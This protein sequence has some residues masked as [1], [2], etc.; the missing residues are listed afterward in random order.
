MGRKSLCAVME[1]VDGAIRAAGPAPGVGRVEDTIRDDTSADT[2][3]TG[4]AALLSCCLPTESS[5]GVKASLGGGGAE[6]APVTAVVILAED[7]AAAATDVDAGGV[8]GKETAGGFLA[9]LGFHFF[10]FHV[11]LG[12]LPAADEADD[13]L[14]VVAEEDAKK[15]DVGLRL[16]EDA[17]R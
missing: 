4:P 17:S 14:S 2:P 3:G 12:F 6:D 1:A 7:A 9:P 10:L 11:P 16:W 5:H 8:K 15:E 13:D